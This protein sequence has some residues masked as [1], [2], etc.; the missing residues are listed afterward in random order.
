MFWLRIFFLIGF[1][2]IHCNVVEDSLNLQLPATEARAFQ[3]AE[4]FIQ[5]ADKRVN[6]AEYEKAL[7]II[8]NGLKKFPQSFVLQFN[9][10]ALLGDHSENF[11]GKKR[12]RMAK[13][14]KE[15]FDRLMGELDQQQRQLFY[16]FKNEYYYRFGN[17]KAQYELGLEYVSEFWSTNEWLPRGYYSQGV[18]AA[19]YARILFLE[20]KYTQARAYAQKAL[21]AWSQY[22]SY[23]NTYYNSY[24]HY[25]YALAIL[26]YTSDMVKALERSAQLINRDLAYV[27]FQ[28]VIQFSEV[29]EGCLEER[30]ECQMFEN[31]RIVD[32][33]HAVAK[34]IPTWDGSCGFHLKNRVD[35]DQGVRAQDISLQAGIGT[36]MDAPAHF[37]QGTEDIADLPL[38]NLMVPV[39]V[40]DVSDRADKEYSIS[41]EDI[42]RFEQVHGRIKEGCCV[43]AYTG[44]SERWSDSSKYRNVDP[45]TGIM[46]FPTWSPEAAQLLLE[47]NVVGIGIDTLS[48]DKEASDFPVHK[49]MLKAKKYI[50]E[51]VAHADKLPATGAYIM[52]MPLKLVGATESPIRLVGLVKVQG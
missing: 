52:A 18:G 21:I 49:V 6:E 8:L 39:V 48:P 41:V 30:F 38:S 37:F 1:F 16:E 45:S 24:V 36:H 20:K 7:E 50:I 2:T 25:A 34:D 43:L 23:T 22:F 19:N 46:Q 31:I 11:T 10:A 28:E 4:S 14:S 9:Y 47:R 33:T 42:H 5:E 51:N 35:Y 15:L 3:A 17:Y 29:V 32:L 27:E 12:Q 40:I 13:R 44:W 26:G